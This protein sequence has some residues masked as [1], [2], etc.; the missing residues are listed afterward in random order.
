[1][2]R[3]GGICNIMDV[4]RWVSAVIALL[5]IILIRL[6]SD[7]G[8][9]TWKASRRGPSPLEAATFTETQ[10]LSLVAAKRGIFQAIASMLVRCQPPS[11]CLYNGLI[12][13]SSV[14]YRALPAFT[15]HT[16]VKQSARLFKNSLNPRVKA[17]G[18][19]FSGLAVV[20]I[21]PYLF[22]SPVEYVTDT[23]FEQLEERW[24]MRRAREKMLE[25]KTDL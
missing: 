18:P 5:P 9:E 12:F 10:R 1:M 21:L 24:Y 20:P 4:S 13:S 7:V 25:K 19:T 14:K 2:G 23:A 11:S 17:W 3:D 15:I 22:D 6:F 8:F 16:V